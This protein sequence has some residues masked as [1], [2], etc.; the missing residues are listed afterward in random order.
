MNIC[1]QNLWNL[2]KK[3]HTLI[4]VN[5]PTVRYVGKKFKYFALCNRYSSFEWFYEK[6]LGTI[7]I[8]QLLIVILI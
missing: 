4:L 3:F 8:K 1:G 2:Q 7:G 6:N 5:D